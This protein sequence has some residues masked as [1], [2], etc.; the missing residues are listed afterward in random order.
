LTESIEEK[1][2]YAKVLFRCLREG[3]MTWMELE[4]RMIAKC[5]THGKFV[6]LMRW[7]VKEEVIIKMGP[8]KS[9]APYQLNP[10]KVAFT[11][12]GEVIIKIS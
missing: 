1:I 6:N 9:R 5:G 4:K 7:L 3:P 10:N 12:E 2:R 8:Q 11:E